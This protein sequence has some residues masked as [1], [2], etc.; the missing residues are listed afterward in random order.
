MPQSSFLAQYFGPIGGGFVIF[1]VI[2]SVL[3]VPY[4][5]VQYGRRGRVSRARF[6]TEFSFL[7]YLIVAW[8]LVL[9][10]F[11][12]QVADFCARVRITPQL[13]PFAWVSDMNYSW[14]GSRESVLDL[15]RNQALLVRLFNVA[16]L[17]PLG[18]YLRRWFRKGF[19][20]TTAA[21]FGLSLCFEITQLT[22]TWFLYEC[23]YRHF[24]VDDLIANTTGAALGWVIAS[25]VRFIPNRNEAADDDLAMAWVRPSL[26]RR[27]TAVLV[28]YIVMLL[29]ALPIALV[30]QWQGIISQENSEF[31][32]MAAFVLIMC[33][34]PLTL[35]ARTPGQ[36][37]IRMRCSRTSDDGFAPASWWQMIIRA[38]V[39]WG[40]IL[41]T[42][43]LASLD[44]L[45]TVTA[46]T[47]WLWLAGLT[48]SCRTQQLGWHERLSR[49]VTQAQTPTPRLGAET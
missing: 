16:L 26:P 28:D 13:V 38:L 27:A 40:P 22:G 34:L 29:T 15:L 1:L 20:W 19:W 42:L 49:T 23:P 46:L 5:I 25:A 39:V 11:P 31:A 7:L 9:L 47:P 48:Y 14:Q 37:L 43:L 30:G 6:F 2:A 17:I 36:W 4:V 44:S 8:C 12:E 32:F 18:V 21:G 33:I 3:L 35:R 41:A 45:S 10:P 24:D